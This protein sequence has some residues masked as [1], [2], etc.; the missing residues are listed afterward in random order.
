MAEFDSSSTIAG[1]AALVCI[2]SLTA[3]SVWDIVAH[4][5]APK[6]KA[7]LYEDKDGV[8][9]EESMAEYSATVPKVLLAIFSSLGLLTAIALAVLATVSHEQDLTLLDNW[10]NVASWVGTRDY[11]QLHC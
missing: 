5:R 11:S 2:F 6:L 8:A 4:F 10:L 7:T 3:P 9:T 1:I